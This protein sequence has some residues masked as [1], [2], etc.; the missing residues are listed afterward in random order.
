MEA[1]DTYDFFRVG[2]LLSDDERQV[3]ETVARFVDERVLPIIAEAFENDRFPK[4]LIPEIASLGL[5]GCNIEGY[6]C[7][8]LNNVAATLLNLLGYETPD[9]YDPSL[10]R[11]D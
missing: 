6:E 9:E 3:R 7:A 11:L 2:G 10:V 8:G 4:D 5:L 1:V